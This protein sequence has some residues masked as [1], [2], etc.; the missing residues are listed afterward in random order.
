M[1]TT[2]P[3]PA[4]VFLDRVIAALAATDARELRKLEA[5]ASGVAMPASRSEYMRKRATLA[6]LLSATARNLRILRR[7]GFRVGSKQ[8]AQPYEQI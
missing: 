1:D 7:A 2:A 3:I 5:A 6:A 4:D 8:T